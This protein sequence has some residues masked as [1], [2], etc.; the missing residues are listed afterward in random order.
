MAHRR[1]DLIERIIN[2]IVLDENDCWV[3]QGA[4]SGKVS[5]GKSGRGY[6]KISVN[7]IF[8]MVHRVMFVC[9]NGYIANKIQVDHKCVNRL[10]CNPAHLEAVTNKVDNKRKMMRRKEKNG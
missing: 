6:G 3:W 7:G 10:C 5:P 1:L 9:Y 2:N 4:T 8:C